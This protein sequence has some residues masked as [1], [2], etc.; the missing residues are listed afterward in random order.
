MAKYGVNGEVLLLT[1]GWR[2]DGPVAA[3]PLRA[4]E[5]LKG[6]YPG[7][8]LM[9][10]PS[11]AMDREKMLLVMVMMMMLKLRVVAVTG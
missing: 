8:R 10:V 6:L 9:R 2:L 4:A 3:A 11:A 7:G 1:L 5:L